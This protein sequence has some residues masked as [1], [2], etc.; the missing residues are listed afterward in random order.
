MLS[1]IWGAHEY[2]ELLLNSGGSDLSLRDARGA[3]I[4]HHAYSYRR[5]KMQ[6]TLNQFRQNNQMMLN[7]NTSSLEST[8]DLDAMLV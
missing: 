3:D 4:F 1:V 7:V 2:F 5:E 6:P 8:V